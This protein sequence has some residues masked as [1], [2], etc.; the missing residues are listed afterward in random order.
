ML[1]PTLYGSVDGALEAS[2]CAWLKLNT[3]YPLGVT[4]SHERPG[5]AYRYREPLYAILEPKA[6]A[7]TVLTKDRNDFLKAVGDAVQSYAEVEKSQ[8]R[9]LQCIL[10]VDYMQAATI[11]FTI[12]N[13]RSRNELFSSLTEHRYNDAY[14]KYWES[15]AAFLH[16]LSIFR[17]AIVHWHPLTIVYV[18]RSGNPANTPKDA[19]TAIRNP[20]P[21]RGSISLTLNEFALPFMLDCAYI[22]AEVDQFSGFLRDPDGADDPTLHE[23]FSQTLPRQNRAVLRPIQPPKEPRSPHLSSRA[24]R[25]PR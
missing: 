23:R 14:K 11:F 16:T 15:C 24:S 10:G 1:G 3:L 6:N 5:S 20:R 8:A 7:M 25:R 22:R 19:Q 21:G 2:P 17:N 4:G 18:N 13:V 9:L 12:Q